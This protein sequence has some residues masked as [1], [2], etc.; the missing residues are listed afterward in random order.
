[1]ERRRL[2][3]T[4]IDHPGRLLIQGSDVYD[5]IVRNCAGPGI[6]VELAFE[7][8]RLTQTF[9]FSFDNFRTIHSCRIVW[10]KGKLAGLEFEEPKPPPALRVGNKAKLRVVR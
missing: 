10:R 8:N 3:R 1:M 7:S 5:C 6:G 2:K 9:D 4:K